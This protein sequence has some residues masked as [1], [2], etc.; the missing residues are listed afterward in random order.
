MVF[1]GKTVPENNEEKLVN[2]SIFSNLVK[3]SRKLHNNGLKF[4]ATV[5]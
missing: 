4:I 1:E 5:C 3:V 2:G